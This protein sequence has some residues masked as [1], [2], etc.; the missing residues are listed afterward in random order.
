[1]ARYAGFARIDASD[2]IQDAYVE[3]VQRLDEY[4]HDPR[5]PFF[6]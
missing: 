6:L 2:V 1:M 4:L 5:L 3:V